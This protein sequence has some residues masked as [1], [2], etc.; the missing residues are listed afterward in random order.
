MAL[1]K[2]HVSNYSSS[3]VGLQILSEQ[4]DDV[5]GDSDV[6]TRSVDLLLHFFFLLVIVFIIITAIIIITVVVV[7]VVVVVLVVLV[8]D[9]Y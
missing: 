6:K 8:F 1:V 4:N 5:G 3:L 2:R 7:V 9:F